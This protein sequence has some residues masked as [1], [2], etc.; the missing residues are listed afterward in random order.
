MY[1]LSLHLPVRS[2]PIGTWTRQKWF[3]LAQTLTLIVKSAVAAGSSPSPSQPSATTLLGAAPKSCR[4]RSRVRRHV[5]DIHLGGLFLIVAGVSGIVGG[6]LLYITSYMTFM[7]DE[8]DFVSSGTS[9]TA[10]VFLL[11]HNEH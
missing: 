3:Q 8:W 10:S 2:E 7:S 9:W 11:P 1:S 4:R 6:V 5:G